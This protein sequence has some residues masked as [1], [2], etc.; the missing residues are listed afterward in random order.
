MEGRERH[1]ER[2]DDVY[3]GADVGVGIEG[4]VARHKSRKKIIPLKFRGA[5]VLAGG[6]KEIDDYR[7]RVGYHDEIHHSL[8]RKYVVYQRIDMHSDQI[9]EP[10]EIWNEKY[11][12]K[13]DHVVDGAIDRII[14]IGTVDLFHKEEEKSVDRPIEE[15]PQVTCLIGSERSEEESLK[16][17]LGL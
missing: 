4:V 10:K 15:Q 12:A 6:E 2:A 3:R 5:Q 13:G 9:D 17:K 16:V 8:E 14:P 1:R 7:R 11:L